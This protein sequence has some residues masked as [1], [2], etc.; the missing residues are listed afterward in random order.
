MPTLD[1]L[2]PGYLRG[3]RL[4]LE[5]DP[6]EDAPRAF[7]P[8][9]LTV[10]Y[11]RTLADELGGVMLPLLFEVQGPSASSYQR[12]EYVRG[13]PPST[14]IW[15]PREGGR[16]LVTLREVAHNYFFGSLVVEVAGEPLEG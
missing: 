3:K 14:I 7:R 11:E 15:T 5:V 13:K 6:D 12:R 16:H 2:A 9:L 10:G 8:L 4:D 1:E